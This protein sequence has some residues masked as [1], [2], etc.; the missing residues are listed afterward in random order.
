MAGRSLSFQKKMQHAAHHIHELQTLYEISQMLVVGSQQKQILSEILEVLDTELGMKNGMVTLLS[1]DGNEIQIEVAHNISEGQSRKVR[2]RVGDGITGRV[3]QTGKP[4]C[5]S[6][7][8]EEPQFLN[9]FE[10]WT[11][12][13]GEISFIC[14]PI[15][16]GTQVIGTISA[17]RVFD[18]SAHLEDDQRVLSIVA[19]MIA[20]DVRSRREAVLQRQRLENENE[21]LRCELEDR[22]RPE[23]IIGNSNAMGDVYHQIH[24]VSGSDTTVLI[25]GESGT[26]K[27]LVAHAIHYSSMRSK[28]PFIKV[29]CASLNENILESELCY[30]CNW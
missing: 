17:D 21:R 5:V 6:K 18:E 28:G 20:N 7:V 12:E 30:F 11:A 25:R 24:Q 19:S 8:S 15:S 23:N 2:Y 13:S 27:E 26:G 4:V 3:M 14:V 29:N 1:P 22:F 9:R 10:R 16:I